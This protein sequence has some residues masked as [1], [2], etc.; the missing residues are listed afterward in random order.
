MVTTRAGAKRN[1]QEAALDT[2]I[3]LIRS[4][5]IDI[6]VISAKKT[7]NERMLRL[8]YEKHIL[9][10]TKRPTKRAKVDRNDADVSMPTSSDHDPGRAS[11]S[12]CKL[13]QVTSFLFL[14][15]D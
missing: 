11:S 13:L 14:R 1:A 6:G 7:P 3:T 12:P 5:L 8:L 2:S 10:P 4:Q 9:F 15:T